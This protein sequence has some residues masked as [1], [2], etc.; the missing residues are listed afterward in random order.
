MKRSMGITLVIS[1]VAI[2]ALGSALALTSGNSNT[3]YNSSMMG[4][5]QHHSVI[6]DIEMGHIHNLM[7]MQN[8][9]LIGTHQGLWS[10]VYGKEA[11]RIGSSQ[12]DVMGLAM[13]N[14][15]MV[16]SGHPG[17]GE[18]SVNNLGFR[19]SMNGG[20]MWENTSLFGKIDFHRLVTSGNTVMGISA[21][22]GGMMRSE[23]A[24]K[25]WANLPN[26]G[27]YD[28]AMDP[29]NSKMV[30]GTTQSGL[31]LSTDGGKNFNAMPNAPILALLSWDKGRIIGVSP[32][33][34]LYQSLDMGTTWEQLA[35]VTGEPMALTARG[36]QIALL[37]GTTVFYSTDTG[38]TFT[39]RI[40]GVPGH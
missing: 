31:L 32:V 6:A 20:M 37:A 8:E 1:S 7:L 9:L 30:M 16:A 4:N 18:E 15:S 25:T 22:D 13:L 39:K 33:G 35:S 27:L 3:D 26:P 14:G 40:I 17:Q 12:F 2:L 28:M 23:D 24:G 29:T 5:S 21:S 36:N 10:Q 19:T 34:Q 11:K 38:M